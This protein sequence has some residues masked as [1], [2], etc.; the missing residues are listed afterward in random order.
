VYNRTI[1]EG[2]GA[3][4]LCLSVGRLDKSVRQG[5]EK[6]GPRLKEGGMARDTAP[7]TLPEGS[8]IFPVKQG[9]SRQQ[10]VRSGLAQPNEKPTIWLFERRTPEAQAQG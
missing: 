10:G 4:R 8:Y 1:R 7:V 3:W 6:T 5:P 2:A 9:H